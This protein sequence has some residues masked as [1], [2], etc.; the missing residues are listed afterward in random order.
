MSAPPKGEP[1]KVD[2]LSR[3]IVHPDIGI[4]E[5]GVNEWH[6]VSHVDEPNH[7]KS[8]VYLGTLVEEGQT[9][10]LYRTPNIDHGPEEGGQDNDNGM[11]DTL[12]PSRVALLRGSSWEKD[13][14]YWRCQ[15]TCFVAVLC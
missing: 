14:K 9:R 4:G 10:P 13:E 8:F 12:I 11:G 6:L 2:V 5:Y 1:S 7:P 3:A 15:C